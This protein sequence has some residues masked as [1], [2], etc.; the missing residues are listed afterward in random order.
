MLL[1]D[2]P[3]G[4]GDVSMSLMELLPDAALIAV[5]TP[6]LAAQKVAERAGRMARDA[7]MPV[8]GVIENMS[9]VACATCGETTP[10]FGSGG[11]SLLAA[12]IA[13]PMLGQIP[14]DVAIREAGDLGIPAV[15]HAPTAKSTLELR[16]IARELPVVHRSLVGRTLPLSVV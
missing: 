2:L 5:T 15:L 12:A 9:V 16:R 3:P 4:T 11:G 14:L 7:R 1:A 13:A 8:A 6:Q 10:V